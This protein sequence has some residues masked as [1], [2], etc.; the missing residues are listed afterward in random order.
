ME[1]G[2]YIAKSPESRRSSLALEVANK[3]VD[4]IQESNYQPGDRIPSEFELAERF[5]V[6]RG[7][8]REA[9]KLLI[10]RNVLEIRPAKGTFLCE[11]PGV[12]SDPLGLAFA[13]DKVKTVQDLLELRVVLECYAVRNAAM[14]ATQE[15]IEEMKTLIN[16]LEESFEDSALCTKYDIE[17]HRCLAESSGNTVM[18]VIIPIVRS[19][20]QHFNNLTFERQWDVV[21]AGHRAIVEAIEMKN[22]MLAEAEMVKHLSYVTEKIKG[23]KEI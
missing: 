13:R 19:G 16:K 5:G 4:F 8:V 17:L 7:T 11:T 20:M 3:L 15:Q 9:V 2:K 6:G 14:M 23:M 10:S 18:P 1:T 21:N 22:P 12:S